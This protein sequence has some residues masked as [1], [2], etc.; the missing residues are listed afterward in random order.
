MLTFIY[1]DWHGW[2]SGDSFLL[3][4]ESV[5]RLR[6]FPGAN[7]AVNWL[8][9]E[10]GDKPAARALNAAIKSHAAR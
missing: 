6:S 4:D 8:Y 9:L 3:S 5:K 2:Q 1:G 10:A 7:E